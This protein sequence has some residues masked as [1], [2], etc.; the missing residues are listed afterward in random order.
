MTPRRIDLPTFIARVEFEVAADDIKDG[1]ERLRVLASVALPV[2]FTM[3]RGR[4]ESGV[5][6]PAE[7]GVTNYGPSTSGSGAEHS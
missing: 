5:D 2:G 7:L 3:I 4:V 6:G 1:G